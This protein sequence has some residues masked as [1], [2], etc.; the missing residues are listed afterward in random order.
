MKII[1]PCTFIIILISIFFMVKDK[2]MKKVL[3]IYSAFLGTILTLSTFNLYK[4]YDVSNYTYMLWLICVLSFVI[5]SVIMNCR[6]KNIE[7]SK[8][9]INFEKYTKS[10]FIIGILIINFIVVLCYKVKYEFII[11]DLPTSEIRM[12][13]F[14][15]LFGS[16]FET[17]FF[18]YIIASIV[19][20]SAIFFSILLV[21]KKIKNIP[22]WISLVTIIL[23]SLI[24]YSR[25]I[26]LNIIIYIVV[27]S[28]ITYKF[29]EILK[30][31]NI[32]ILSLIIILIFGAFVG[33]L[34][35][36]MKQNKLSF[37]ENLKN[38]IDTQIQQI[39]EYTM[40]GLRLLDNFI[41]NGFEEIEGY[42]YGRATIAGIEEILLYPI[43]AVGF[44]IDSFNNII[45]AITQENKQIGE[46]TKY[47]NAF[48]TSIMNFY[49]DFGIWGVVI[50]PIIHAIFITIVVKNY[51]KKRSLESFLLLDYVVMN[52]LFSVI[53]WNYQFG[54]NIFILILLLMLNMKG[55]VYEFFKEYGKK[56][57][58]KKGKHT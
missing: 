6:N 9:T 49:L 4:L 30:P 34:Y 58:A 43:K 45:G 56:I 14:T 27:C 20:I 36:R 42:T 46:N 54:S 11:K 18:N 10:K 15:L 35:S 32:L 47:F 41:Q 33:M 40:G 28:T 13:K 2:T 1:L 23:Y 39:F 57:F 50:I 16:A 26:F 3:Y 53:R 52:L 38:T 55:K 24:G 51:N 19:Y 31:K 17:L 44:E 25:M 12:A 7:E 8:K 29:K 22:F 37:Q 48:Y 21:N 5:A